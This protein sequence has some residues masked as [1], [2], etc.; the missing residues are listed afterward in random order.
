MSAVQWKWWRETQLPVITDW[1]ERLDMQ[2]NGPL[3][4]ERQIIEHRVALVA[5]N[6]AQL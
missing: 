5:R 4:R 3:F 1:N 6:S 2:V